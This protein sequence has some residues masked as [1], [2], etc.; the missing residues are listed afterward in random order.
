[1]A[2]KANSTA[3]VSPLVGTT[4]PTSVLSSWLNTKPEAPS[5]SIWCSA[6]GTMPVSEHS[7]TVAPLGMRRSEPTYGISIPSAR[8]VS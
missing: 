5:T 4:S 3:E 7:M 8:H 2:P 1:M 6:P